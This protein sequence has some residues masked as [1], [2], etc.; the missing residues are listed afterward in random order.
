MKG[1]LSNT[2]A[3]IQIL[4]TYARLMIFFGI[5]KYLEKI[6]FDKI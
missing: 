6:K 5:G 3:K 1:S 2:D 4:T